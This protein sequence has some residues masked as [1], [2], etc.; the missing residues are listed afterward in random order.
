MKNGDEKTIIPECKA[1]ID[2]CKKYG[3]EKTLSDI[4]SFLGGYFLQ[5]G[6]SDSA[7]KYMKMGLMFKN[8]SPK[9][10]GANTMDLSSIYCSQ[11]RFE[12]ARQLLLE[13]NSLLIQNKLDYLLLP[14]Y[15]MLSYIDLE[16]KNCKKAL[17]WAN[18]AEEYI[19]I[20]TRLVA[21]ITHF[22]NKAKLLQ[23]L[24]QYPEALDALWL[25][26]YY[27]DSLQLEDNQTAYRDL[28][29]KY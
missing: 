15:G 7:E 23:F 13:V 18:K 14:Y 1:A 12:E 20:E 11:R 3:F 22:N 25:T 16:L 19:S 17:E 27:T 8:A 29:K 28:E 6:Q 2:T 10:R 9:R 4:S 21:R 5:I 26:L 24:E